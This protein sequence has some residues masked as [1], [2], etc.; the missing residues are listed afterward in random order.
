MTRCQTLSMLSSG[1][2]SFNRELVK[3]NEDGTDAAQSRIWTRDKKRLLR[4][5]I[6]SKQPTILYCFIFAFNRV[7]MSTRDNAHT[8]N[9]EVGWKVVGNDRRR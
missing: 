3:I 9:L 7:T 8:I 6:G 1:Y 4:R 5:A 2:I